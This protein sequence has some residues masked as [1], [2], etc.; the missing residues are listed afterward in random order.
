V[1]EDCTDIDAGQPPLLVSLVYPGDCH[2]DD[3][4]WE[5]STGETV[6]TLPPSHTC[7]VLAITDCLHMVVSHHSHICDLTTSSIAS[8]HKLNLE[9][10]PGLPV[11]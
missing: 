9:G 4:K 8:C 5:V 7:D 1:T 11:I 10:K 3:S 6:L 2:L